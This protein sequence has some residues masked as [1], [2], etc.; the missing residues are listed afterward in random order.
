[1]KLIVQITTNF[2]GIG[3][4][5]GFRVT[6]ATALSGMGADRR[7]SIARPQRPIT[8]SHTI[9]SAPPMVPN[10]WQSTNTSNFL[11]QNMHSSTTVSFL[12]SNSIA[13][14]HTLAAKK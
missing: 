11:C 9:V 6:I 2:M 7:A 10:I 13:R 4:A 8:G 1:M 3:D 14:I 12:E 5:V